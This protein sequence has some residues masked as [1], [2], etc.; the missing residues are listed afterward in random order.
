MNVS[1][2]AAALLAQA[3]ES[4][5]RRPGRRRG[6]APPSGGWSRWLREPRNAVWIALAAL[7]AFGGVRRL[8][9]WWEARATVEQLAADNLAPETILAA[10]GHGRAALI[11]LFRILGTG[12]TEAQR[13]AA[14]QA[15]SV[16]WKQ[17]NLI[18][19]EEKAL[20]RRGFAV[21]WRARR[22][23]PRALRAPIP[24]AVTY[25]VPFLGADTGGVTPANLEWSHRIVGARR[26][27][28]EAFSPW[29][30]GL[31]RAEFTVYPG[32]FETNGPHRLV[33]QAK[34][35]TTGLTGTW[36]LELPHV[37][38]SFEF[39][40]RLAIDALLAAPDQARG[41]ALARSIRLEPIDPVHGPSYF[42]LNDA[43]ALRNP[44]TIVVAG[45]LP[46]DLAHTAEA[47]FDGLPGRFAAGALIV[48]GQATQ[49][50]SRSLR[51][52]LTLQGPITLDRPGPR[53]LRL[54]LTPD[55]DRGWADPDVRSLWP[56]TIMTD[57]A[58]VEVVRR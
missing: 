57:W 50:L 53:R 21:T 54:V 2:F 32:D 35:R 22:R 14:G 30:P 34:A 40:P 27:D 51:F 49:A 6:G 43:F 8:R 48:T 13:N 18:T 1:H 31:A 56:E 39:D 36:E 58:E 23:Y 45:P 3:A 16:I 28:L 10:A 11:E 52:S 20:V 47:E 42:P 12:E 38:F 4:P 41:E 7:V 37:Q 24:I 9:Q 44:P 46:F 25:G 17:D 55:P 29:T 33:L 19:E 15:L 5:A 26:A